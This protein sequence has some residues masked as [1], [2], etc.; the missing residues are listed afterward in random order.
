MCMSGA[1]SGRMEIPDEAAAFIGL[2]E[3]LMQSYQAP[4]AE[5][6]LELFRFQAR[7]NPVYSAY[8]KALG[9]KIQHISTVD[10]IPCMPTSLFRIHR[11]KSWRYKS[12]TIWSSSA[13]TS[14]TPSRHYVPSLSRFHSISRRIFEQHYGACVD[15]IIIALLPSYLERRNSG[16]VCMVDGLMAAAGHPLSGFY[17]YD[18]HALA[19]QYRKACNSDRKIMLIGVGFALL[20]LADRG[21]LGMRP[22]DIVMETGGMK[23]RGPELVREAL[24]DRLCRGLKTD[25]IHTEYGMTELSSSA[26]SQGSGRLTPPPWMKVRIQDLHDP[27]QKLADGKTGTIDIIDFANVHS[28]SF[29]KTDDL[30]W[31]ERSGDFYVLGRRDESEWR[32]C[33]LLYQSQNRL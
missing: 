17:M 2:F 24:H 9:C 28:C 29:I 16:L 15:W 25:L 12:H 27:L 1:K 26:F 4:G 14:Q 23:G 5:D 18:H 19:E 8:L 11:V 30:G 21:L 33:N 31:T 22:Q 32:G 6:I 13:T 10:E 20:D 3:R 7:V